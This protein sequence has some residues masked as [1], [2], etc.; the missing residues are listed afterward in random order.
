[1]KKNELLELTFGFAV[2]IVKY[3]DL[4]EEHRKFVLAR[5]ILKSGTSIGANA[6]EAQSSESMSDFVHKLKIADKEA[7]ETE[8]WLQLCK[9]SPG[10]PDP[11]ELLNDIIRIRKILCSIIKTSKSKL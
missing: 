11:G 8:Y 5:Q 10:Y 9:A 1:V 2:N 6:R 3:S 7:L 4:L